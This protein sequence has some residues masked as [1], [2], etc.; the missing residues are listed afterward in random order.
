MRLPISEDERAIAISRWSEL[1]DEICGVLPDDQ[2]EPP[3]SMREMMAVMIERA[4][5]GV[6]SE[7]SQHHATTQ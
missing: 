6:G 5:M 4:V 2:Y 1:V 3:R 7:K